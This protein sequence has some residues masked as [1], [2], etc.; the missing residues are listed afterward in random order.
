[1]SALP[2]EAKACVAD[3]ISVSATDFPLDTELKTGQKVDW[4]SSTFDGLYLINVFA[5][6][7]EGS[8]TRFLA[9]SHGD[10]GILAC[11]DGPFNSLD[12]A[13][14]NYTTQEVWTQL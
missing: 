8:R 6:T 13:E 12:A 4:V 14:A 3:E 5:V 10:D 1:M 2:A 7:E 9:L 11:V